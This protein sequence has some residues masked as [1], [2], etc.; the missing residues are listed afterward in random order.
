MIGTARFVSTGVHV[1]SSDVFRR[2]ID[3]YTRRRS[4]GLRVGALGLG[5]ATISGLSGYVVDI[6]DGA[7][8]FRLDVNPGEVGWIAA[9]TG[10]AFVLGVGLT[11]LGCAF[12][13]LESRREQQ[14]LSRRRVFVLEQRGLVDTSDSAL[15]SNL[16]RTIL[17]TREPMLVDIRDKLRAGSVN[18]PEAALERVV[19]SVH[20]LRRR[21]TEVA[22]ED[23]VVVYGGIMPVPFAFLTGM[24]LDDEGDVLTYDW[25]RDRS[26]WR[27]LDGED[28]GERLTAPDLAGLN[29]GEVVLAVSVSYRV[30]KAS[31]ARTFPSIPVVHME[32]PTKAGDKHW[33]EEKVAALASGFRE[34]IKR[35][36]E[37]GVT[38]IHL[39]IAAPNSVVFR[40]GRSFDRR[41][42][43]PALIYQY[44]RT[45][46]PPYPWGVK[47]PTHGV[48]CPRVV[49]VLSAELASS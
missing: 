25:D 7:W 35:L 22:R 38:S 26:A 30:D 5:L 49:R 21:R 27:Q 34:A 13:L 8:R 46:T 44:E 4:V 1:T 16:P 39:I 47:L 36:D 17:G 3:W 31:I 15:N 18:D 28:D 33:S 11:C 41:L 20:E 45:D 9:A 14:R 10:V 29:G 12:A 43:P 6:R 48:S 42:A 2:L 23:C 37:R 40:L 19:Q 32:V 24:L